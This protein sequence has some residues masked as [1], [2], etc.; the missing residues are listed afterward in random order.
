MTIGAAIVQP[1]PIATSLWFIIMLC[2]AG[3]YAQESVPSLRVGSLSSA[4]RIDGRLDEAAWQST[5]S[6]DT[7]LQ[8]DPQEGAPPSVRTIVRVVADATALVIGIVCED[9]PANIVSRSVARDA[10]LEDEDHIQVVLG[11]FR[12]GRSGYAFAINP[13]GARND[14]LIGGGD[15]DENQDW[16]GIWEAA[17]TRQPNGWSAEIRIPIQTLSFNSSLREWDFNVQ[18]RLERRLET[19]RWAFPARQ[20][21]VVQTSRAGLLTGLPTFDVGL[22]LTVRPAV[23]TGAGVP[24]SGASID[25]ELQP[26]LDVIQR[27]GTNVTASGTT[28]TDFAETEVDTRRTNLT[29]FPLFFPEK[30]TFFLEGSDIFSFGVGLDEDVLP[31]F[32]RRIGLVDG[33]EV[34]ILAGGKING[35]AGNTNFGG[36]VV[37]TNDRQGVVEDEALMTVARV[38]QNI[39][40]ESWVGAIATVGDPLGRSGSWLAGADFTYNTS[41][42][43]GDKNFLVGVWGLATGR[44]DLGGDASAYGFKVDYPNDEWDI[45]LTGKRIGRNFDPSL[46]F[47]PRPA[48]YL[49]DAGIDNQTRIS[50][51]PF[52]QLTHEFRPSIAA[53]LSGRWESYRVFIAPIN[54]EFRSGDRVEFNANPT[55]ERLV[56]PFEI[57][58]GVAIAPGSYHWLRYRFEIATAEKRRAFAQVTWWTGGFYDGHLDQL[59][60]E[61]TWNPVAL[62]TLEISGE[63]NLGRLRAGRFTQTLVG[64]RAQL[65]LSPDVSVSSYIQYDT[66]SDLLGSN[67]RLRWTLRPQADL[68]I[69]YNHNVRSLEDRWQKDSNQLLVKLQYAFRF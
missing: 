56:E 52:R 8:T 51:G 18:R 26:S 33:R 63:R 17:A 7:F 61:A 42:F 20:Y 67:T 16:D 50:R 48:V 69:V 53:D 12:D 34:P 49:V 60:W 68:F 3:V 6:T 54:W 45:Q 31:Y 57:A 37:G 46:G 5:E 35:R 40:R 21:R 28:N 44:D 11:P 29:R 24:A 64:T 41:R 9:D 13:S 30:R 43:R 15:D 38:K 39:L 66:E 55:G 19:N 25:G 62:L 14:G 59:A 47:V 10:D 22:G 65:N 4:I 1:W 58:D 23:S 27:L 32:S 36:L 2:G